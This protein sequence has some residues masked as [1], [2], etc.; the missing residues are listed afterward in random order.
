[1]EAFKTMLDR[2]RL[3]E[4][5][6]V[7]GLGKRLSFHEKVSSTNDLALDLANQGAPHGTLII[8]KEQFA[9]RGQ[10]NRIWITSSG[11][12]LAISVI[13]RPESLIQGAWLRLH[14]LGA[15]AVSDALDELG[16]NAFVKWPNDVLLE[17]RKVA[18]VLVEASW[19]G[20]EMEFG[21]LGIGINVKRDVLLEARSLDFPTISIDEVLGEGLD[22]YELL[23]QVLRAITKWF[24]VINEG[25]FI[26]QWSQK[27]AYRG[28][29]IV[30]QES[31]GCWSGRLIGLDDHGALCV[32]R[33]KEELIIGDMGEVSIRL[34]DGYEEEF[35]HQG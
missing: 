9:G 2:K 27:L 35:Y 24:V 21:I 15:L 29:N 31:E 28:K 6:P 5:L 22:W 16:L 33:G 30:V 32:K 3:A 18:G 34:E 12:G 4:I 10:K 13:L 23:T 17:G 26:E 25:I 7:A 19:I 8:A 1:M 14:A 11:H 20:E